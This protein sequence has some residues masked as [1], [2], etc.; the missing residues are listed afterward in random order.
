VRRLLTLVSKQVL[1]V[2]GQFREYDSY[3][4]ILTGLTNLGYT[5]SDSSITMNLSNMNVA[6]ADP[7]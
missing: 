6:V 1:G 3:E 4:H 5:V 7:R 2:H